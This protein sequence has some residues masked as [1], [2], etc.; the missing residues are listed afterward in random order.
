ME[1]TVTIA[2]AGKGGTGKTTLS[3]LL[4]RYVIQNRLGKVLAIDADPSSNLHLVLG[5]SL[6]KTVGDIREDARDNVPAGMSRQDWLDYAIRTAM[7]EGDAFDLLAMG[8]PEGRGCY[9]A[10][11]HLLRN[12]VDGICK[13]YDFVIMDNEAGMEHLSRR[14]TRDVDHLLL[15]SD[16]SLRGL[17][18]AEAMLA[19]SKEL[20]ISV[21][22]TYLVVNRVIGELPSA[23]DKKIEAFG[24]PLLA[25]I[26]YD[27]QI[28][29]F[30]SNGRPLVE[31][32][33]D[34][35]ISQAVAQIARQLLESNRR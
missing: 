11:N 5:M 27:P 1:M 29:E 30:D 26:P 31:L 18:A 35:P 33:N 21:S 15:V 10:A 20:E 32:P 14:T 34:A 25:K 8:R 19:L 2:V 28:V 6:T 4:T 9:C 7:E 22:K 23:W 17:A 24:V 13:T 3:G 16:S 12:I